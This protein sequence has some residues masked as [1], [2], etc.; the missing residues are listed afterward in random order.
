MILGIGTDLVEQKR[1]EK[2]CERER[3]LSLCYTEKEMVLLSVKKTRAAGHFAVKEAVAKALGTGFR[4]FGPKDIEV[5][6]DELGKPVV[7]LYGDA[8][9]LSEQLGVTHI[10]VSITDEGGFSM[11]VAV[12]EG[13]T[14]CSV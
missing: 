4:G 13:E 9:H 2:A 5:L 12:L 1:I 8:K 6:R 3:F 7:C 14:P 11:A 10:F